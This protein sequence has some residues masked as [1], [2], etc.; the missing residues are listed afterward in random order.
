[1][2]MAKGK[3]LINPAFAGAESLKYGSW[4][5]QL[6]AINY[7]GPQNT[8][9]DIADWRI[10]GGFAQATPVRGLSVGANPSGYPG[11]E[12]D[13]SMNNMI[14]FPLPPDD[15]SAKTNTAVFGADAS[16]NPSAAPGYE[17]DPNN[18]IL[19]PWVDNAGFLCVRPDGAK[20]LGYWIRLAVPTHQDQPG[21]WRGVNAQPLNGFGTAGG[22]AQ[23]ITFSVDMQDGNTGLRR[24]FIQQA[25]GP[26][27]SARSAGP[28]S[29]LPT[30]GELDPPLVQGLQEQGWHRVGGGGA[31]SKPPPPSGSGLPA[32]AHRLP[33]FMSRCALQAGCN[34]FDK[35]N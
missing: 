32:Q 8:G 4:L 19:A 22:F 6:I 9:G 29:C 7:N 14:T 3:H 17:L 26:A 20:A 1:M 13:P 24:G 33:G 35:L 12:G 23:D 10:R 21:F 34:G 15:H 30:N 2:D 25:F 31:F 27:M 5:S 11:L 28:Y 16:W 18:T